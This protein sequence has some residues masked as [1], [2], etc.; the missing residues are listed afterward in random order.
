MQAGRIPLSELAQFIGVAVIA[1]IFGWW[2]LSPRRVDVTY[3]NA[4]RQ[5]YASA[6]TH[7][8]TV[9]IDGTIPLQQD[10]PR[11]DQPTCG[12]MRAHYPDKKGDPRAR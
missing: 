3:I 8:D 7:A 11:V 9:R 12:V 2:W 5:F 10:R 6:H 4:C 1:L